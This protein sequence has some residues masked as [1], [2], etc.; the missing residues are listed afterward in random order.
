MIHA[1]DTGFL[2]AA[3]VIEHPKHASA[4][5]K[6]TSL[7]TLGDRFALAPQV[8]MEFIHIVTDPK[9][10]KAPL[11]MNAARDVAEKWWTARE[12]IRI[13]A[14]E[15]SVS[16]FFVWH[17]KYA[18]GRKRILDTLLAATYHSATIRSILTTNP[19]DFASLDN[20]E[21]ITP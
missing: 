7:V 6:L 16:Q 4:C 17:Q 8:V 9:R 19:D 12:V 1:L 5:E 10:F 3:E 2:V 13:F 21:C 14:T 15:A 18:L 20:F 11:N